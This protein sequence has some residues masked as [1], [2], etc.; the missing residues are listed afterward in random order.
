M[1]QNKFSIPNEKCIELLYSDA[2]EADAREAFTKAVPQSQDAFETGCDFIASDLSIPGTY[3]ITAEDK[4]FP[5]ALQEQVVK[6]IP[7]IK[8]VRLASGHF[9]FLGKAAETAK[10]VVNIV[11][12][13]A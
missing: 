8:E 1:Q 7:G 4:S 5:I 9:P 12:G 13:K 3:V 6:S 11:E 2:N 10:L